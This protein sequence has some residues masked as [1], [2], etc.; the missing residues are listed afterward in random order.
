M[1]LAG[2]RHQQTATE[3]GMSNMQRTHPQMV[4]WI[5]CSE[6]MVADSGRIM[7][8]KFATVDGI[9]QTQKN[10]SEVI[11]NAVSEMAPRLENN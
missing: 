9:Q 1:E 11:N 7:E 3:E 8:L 6:N 10:A 5:L 4:E 2:L